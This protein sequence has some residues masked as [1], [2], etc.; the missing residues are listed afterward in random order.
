MHPLSLF[1]FCPKCGSDKFLENSK[2]SKKCEKCHFEY[3]KPVVA[4]T[5]ALIFD[6]EGRLLVTRRKNDPEKDTLDLPGGFVDFGE[7]IEE[8]VVREIKEEANIDIEVEK[9]L[10][11]VPNTYIYSGFDVK[12][13][14]FVISCRAKNIND[15]AAEK[16]EISDLYFISIPDLDPENFG[17]TS[18]KEVI[19]RIKIN[20]CK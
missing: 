6:Y 9:Y 2:N 1:S 3:Y 20:D 16:S 5:V 17:L 7:T 15:I 13:L 12:T 8:C 18:I 10:F 14:D 4:A 11:C 19:R